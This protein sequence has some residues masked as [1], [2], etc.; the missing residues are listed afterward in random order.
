MFVDPFTFGLVGGAVLLFLSGGIS[1][2]VL[3]R[4]SPSPWRWPKGIVQN[5]YI[6]FDASLPEGAT[7]KSYPV[8]GRPEP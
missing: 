7:G 4:A 3:R 1:F 6:R 8:E 2:L 5:G